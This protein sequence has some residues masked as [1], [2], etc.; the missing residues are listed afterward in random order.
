MTVSIDPQ[1]DRLMAISQARSALREGRVRELRESHGLSQRELARALGV[2][3]TALSR[4][5][6]GSRMPRSGAAERLYGVL[7]VLEGTAA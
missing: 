5:E 1:V 4:W 6:N 7:K 2:D 3:E